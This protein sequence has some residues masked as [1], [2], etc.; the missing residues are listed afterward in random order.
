MGLIILLIIK[1]LDFYIG[2]MII[3]IVMSWLAAFNVINM[4]NQ[5]VNKIYVGLYK[6]VDPPLFWVRKVIPP[7]GGLDLSPMVVMFGVYIIKNLLFRI[8]FSF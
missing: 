6:I 2:I 3:S 5:W 4:R 8:L 1:L 7:A